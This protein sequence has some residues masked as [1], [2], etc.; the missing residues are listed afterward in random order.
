M[1]RRIAFL[2]LVVLL[3]CSTITTAAS[4]NT[5][6][7]VSG[8]T[9][10]IGNETYSLV[11]LPEVIIAYSVYCQMYESFK[12]LQ[13]NSANPVVKLAKNMDALPGGISTGLVLSHWT[14][15]I[16]ND[17][18]DHYSGFQKLNGKSLEQSGV[19]YENILFVT[20]PIE[21]F[22]KRSLLIYSGLRPER[23]QIYSVDGNLNASLLYD[24][25]GKDIVLKDKRGAH[26]SAL[27]IYGVR[28]IKPGLFSLQVG[29]RRAEED[30]MP[31]AE[32]SFIINVT[33]NDFKMELL[34]N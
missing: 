33:K 24:S 20:T 30:R 18:K 27:P 7:L 22:G 5:P 10:T 6:S 2:L 21:S 11:T 14:F 29:S 31:E 17:I 8:S 26:W 4:L 23:T 9:L 16:Q 1:K 25:F 28:V 15:I 19:P 3:S 32:G 12:T 34:N 13:T